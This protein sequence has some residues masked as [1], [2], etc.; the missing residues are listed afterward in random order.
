MGDEVVSINDIPVDARSLEDAQR[1]LSESAESV[2]LKIRRLPV[3]SKPLLQ[4]SFHAF[5]YI[6]YSQSVA[7]DA[8]LLML[9]EVYM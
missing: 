7:F 9:M 5:H 3:D 8:Y 6:A 2:S 4:S 1:I